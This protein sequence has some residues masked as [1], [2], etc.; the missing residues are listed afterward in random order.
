MKKFREFPDWPLDQVE[1][2]ARMLYTVAP[3][4][5]ELWRDE[6]RWKSLARQAFDFLDNLHVAC[7]QIAK[8]RRTM[9]EHYAALT[10]QFV[11]TDKLPEIVPFNKT[12]RIVTGESS[13]SRA[14][15]KLNKVLKRLPKYVSRKELRRWQND[16]IPRDLVRE[17][18]RV[19]ESEWPLVIAEQN[20]AR[21]KRRAARSDKRRGAKTPELQTALMPK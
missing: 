15:P 20:S 4:R 6:Y 18:K 19:F 9:H 5:S 12:A 3:F 11:E 17:L 10:A 8:Q 7:E 2:V 13:T 16:G 21:R 14:V 1:E